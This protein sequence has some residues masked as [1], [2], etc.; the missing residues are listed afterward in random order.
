[1]KTTRTAVRAKET[2]QSETSQSR[3]IKGSAWMTAGS[4]FSR[5]LGAIYIIPWG[6]MMGSAVDRSLANALYGKGYNVYSL[7]LIISTAG[8]P[9]AV[10]KQ[11]AHYNAINEY[12]ISRNLFKTGAKLMG[13]LGLVSA[14]IMF[15]L[16]P[17]LAAGDPDQIPVYRSLSIALTIIPFLS[18]TRGYF[19][20]FSD[21]APSAISQFIEQVGRVAYMLVATFVIMKLVRGNYPAAVTQ[22]TFAAFIGAGCGLG[23][24]GWFYLRRKPRYD[25][26]VATSANKVKVSR[27]H[28]M[29]E[30]IQQSLPF[31]FLDSGIT[32]FML[33]DQYSFNDWMQ[34]FYRASN[35]QLNI[36]FALFN[37][38]ANKLTMIVV[39]LAAAVA[40]TAIPLLSGAYTHRN[41]RLIGQQIGSILQLFLVIMVPASIG[42]A[43]LA[44]PLYTVFYQYSATG[45]QIL[46]LAA[47]VA[48]IQGLFTVLAATLQGLYQNRL[49][50]LYLGIGLIVKLLFQGF[51]IALW[52]YRGPLI[53]SAIGFSAT[54]A[55]MLWTLHRRFRFY[56]RQ[57]VKRCLAI[58]LFSGLMYV[59]VKVV[60]WGL[61]HFI[62]PSD[63]YLALLVGGIGLLVGVSV[64]GYC[65]LKTRLAD[66]IL[67]VKGMS[68]LRK[69]VG[70]R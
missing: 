48:I 9:G 65:I 58:I 59:A 20:G 13:F 12:G 15:L 54:C 34:T 8:I 40:V 10:A 2:P 43:A 21:M 57:T 29:W 1:M 5:F 23:I 70:I 55:L 27:R 38:N 26:L 68:N 7:F 3:L 61:Y 53:S 25:A 63:R 66:R 46:K 52:S 50:I 32:L 37:F 69:R 60:L 67:G 62:A 33:I 56:A 30:I 17:L 4:I 42:L 45:V 18:L 35:E 51:S 36:L 64:Y 39:S 11:I 47:L 28:L 16:A 44:Q 41:L 22:S 24:L 14:V 49:A 31:I 6:M 19:Q